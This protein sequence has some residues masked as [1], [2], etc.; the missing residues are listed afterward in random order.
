LK[1]GAGAEAAIRERN[2]GNLR[3]VQHSLF[4]SLSFYA[5]DDGRRFVRQSPSY[6]GVPSLSLWTA[7]GWGPAVNTAR[8]PTAGNPWKMT[9]PSDWGGSTDSLIP[10]GNCLSDRELR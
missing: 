7:K 9:N 8:A 5:S 1:K 2:T 4:P 6:D 3:A 10:A